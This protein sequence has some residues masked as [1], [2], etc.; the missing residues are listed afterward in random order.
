MM[1]FLR[2]TGGVLL[3]AVIVGSML[4]FILKTVANWVNPKERPVSVGEQEVSN[5]GAKPRQ[6]AA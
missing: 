1:E 6:T 2:F 5:P 3:S 4:A